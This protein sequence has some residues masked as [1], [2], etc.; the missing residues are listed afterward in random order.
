MFKV[1]FC[2]DKVGNIL[3]AMY[4]NM[5]DLILS[6]LEIKDYM[7]ECKVDVMCMTEKN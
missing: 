5:D 1:Q 2:S 3:R 6:L 4:T 7:R